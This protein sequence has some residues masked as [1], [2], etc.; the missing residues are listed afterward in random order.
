MPCS[1]LLR[2][3]PGAVAGQ[4]E[5]EPQARVQSAV[6]L[7]AKHGPGQLGSLAGMQTNASAP[8]WPGRV[9]QA[10][11]WRSWRAARRRAPSMC[12]TR[13]GRRTS[14]WMWARPRLRSACS[15]SPA[16]PTRQ[17][18]A[19]RPTPTGTAPPA[20]SLCSP[21]C[22]AYLDS[23]PAVW[24][25]GALDMHQLRGVLTDRQACQCT[26]T[27]MLQKSMC[28]FLS[29]GLCSNIMRS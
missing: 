16:T 27:C 9:L 5:E 1:M 25:G 10:A 23:L 29:Q 18:P 26:G 22:H 7:A 19:S 12:A 24:R 2:W 3:C 6:G 28:A 8:S 4:H 20:S 17:A 21:V 11:A 14:C 15:S 13:C